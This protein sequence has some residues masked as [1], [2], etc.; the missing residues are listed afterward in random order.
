MEFYVCQHC[1]NVV[2]FVHN[3]GVPIV[4]CGE[5]MHK[6][7]PN[8]MDAA[9]EKH[10]PVVTVEGNK[11]TVCAG[12]VAHPMVEDHYI[13]WIAL[14]TKQGNQWKE[15]KPGAEPKACFMLCEGDQVLDVYAY[16]NLHGLWKK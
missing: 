3:A 9:Q 13:Q 7:E 5:K 2:A 11:V 4:C 8:T 1:G 15:L 16:C 6:I 14:Q 10:V 12:S